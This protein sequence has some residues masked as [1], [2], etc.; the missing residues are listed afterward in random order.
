MMKYYKSACEFDETRVHNDYSAIASEFCDF[1]A[2]VMT[3]RLINKFTETKLLEKK[4]YGKIMSILRRAKKVKAD[5]GGWRLIKM[6]P[7]QVK[8]L[9]SLKLL[10][11]IEEPVHRPVGRPPKPQV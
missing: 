3:Y 4:N 7:S 8:I 10:E 6:N 1:L 5:N 2:T 11:A 9:E